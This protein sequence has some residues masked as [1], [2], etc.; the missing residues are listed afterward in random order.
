MTRETILG[1]F[2]AWGCHAYQ[3]ELAAD[4]LGEDAAPHHL[5]A[6]PAGLG[7]VLI[8]SQIVKF[9]VE[10]KQTGRVLVVAP[11]AFCMLWRSRLEE[12]VP[13]VPVKLMYGR[14]FR[15]AAEDEP[16][17][18]EPIVAIVPCDTAVRPDVRTILAS[19]SWDMVIMA[20]VQPHSRCRSLG[21]YRQML[22]AG[23]VRRSLLIGPAP[24]DPAQKGEE[25]PLPDFQVTNWLGELSDWE[26]SAIEL[27]PIKWRVTEY[28]RHE[29][30]VQFLHL[31]QEQLGQ[32][33]PAHSPFGFETRLLMRRAI[34]SPYA[35]QR[36][37]EIMGRKL[38]RASLPKLT[39]T[40]ERQYGDPTEVE[41]VP[42][43]S[44]SPE[45]RRS[46]LQFV[47]TAFDSL[48]QAESDAKLACLLELLDDLA[49]S[50]PGRICVLSAFAETASYLHSALS[51]IGRPSVTVNGGLRYAERQ[52]AMKDF[53][54]GGGIL[55][56]TPGA[57]G[58]ESDLNRVKHV[59]HYD[60]P[61]SRS[62]LAQ[63]EGRFGRINRTHA[64]RMYALEDLSAAAGDAP[65]IEQLVGEGRAV[66]RNRP[67][68]AV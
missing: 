41:D 22:S 46:Y 62:Q 55:L 27:P 53:V 67:R 45:A 7:K 13:Q 18:N 34:S 56:A 10:R 21:L 19:A 60:L 50:R 33:Q 1:A 30:E 5:L 52:Q 4:F 64:C 42:H 31:L 35:A 65:S 29:R 24:L 2:R 26:G 57:L 17:Q 16:L 48:Q 36:T 63:I 25:A 32:A 49:D 58:E 8:A 14:T 59:V 23:T 68:A 47:Q 61:T 51:E 15:E 20:E 28:T 43:L 44:F 39:T 9:M 37:L 11:S 54:R 6:T 3:A 12:L 66:L 40:S 38:G